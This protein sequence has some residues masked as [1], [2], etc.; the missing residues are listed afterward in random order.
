MVFESSA[1]QEQGSIL[2]SALNLGYERFGGFCNRSFVCLLCLLFSHWFYS[3]AFLKCCS[4]L[5]S[6]PL[7]SS[8]S[9]P[10]L[11]K[12]IKKSLLILHRSQIWRDCSIYY[13]FLQSAHLPLPKSLVLGEIVFVCSQRHVQVGDQPKQVMCGH[14]PTVVALIFQSGQW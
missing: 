8:L 11:L 4:C 3:Q 13:A 2:C 14:S 12:F 9:S 10:Q 6:F 7:Q 1:S 5:V